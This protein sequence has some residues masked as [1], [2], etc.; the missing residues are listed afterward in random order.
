MHHQYILLYQNIVNNL[1]YCVS[2][3]VSIICLIL[4]LYCISSSCN[5]INAFQY[6]WSF[7]PFILVFVEEIAGVA[8]GVGVASFGVT[9]GTGVVSTINKNNYFDIYLSKN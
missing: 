8:V 6:P 4:Y 7:L 9:V 3:F 5:K 1:A 2:W